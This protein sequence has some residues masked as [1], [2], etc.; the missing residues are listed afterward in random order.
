MASVSRGCFVVYSQM[1]YWTGE[2][3]S[4]DVG[5]ALRFECAEH[6][7]AAVRA[8]GLARQLSHQA[9]GTGVMYCQPTPPAAQPLPCP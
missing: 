5:A 7:D 2:A 9:A 8:D 6:F 1:G 3:W 4:R